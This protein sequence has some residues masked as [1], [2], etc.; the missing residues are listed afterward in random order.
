MKFVLFFLTL[1][2]CTSVF[3]IGQTSR[4]TAFALFAK[5]QSTLF[6]KAYKSKDLE[7][8]EALL[9]EFVSRYNALSK[10]EQKPYASYVNSYYNVSCA[11]SLLGN[12]QMAI[13]NLEKAIKGGYTNYAHIVADNDLDN[14]RN[15]K[16]FIALVE[17]LRSI[18]DYLYILKADNKRFTAKDSVQTLAFTYQSSDNPSLIQLRKQFKL[19]SIAGEGN[20]V[21]KMINVL[22]WVH[23]TIQH[24]GQHESGIKVINGLEIASVTKAKSIGVSC[25]ELATVLNDCYL[26]LGFKSR[27][28]YCMPKDTLNNDYD[29]HVI[30]AVYSAQ[31]KKWLWMDPTNDAYVMNEKGELLGIDE[32]RN[33]LVNDQPLILNP[34]ANWNHRAS[35]TKENYLY[36]YMAKNLYRFSCILENCFD[37]ETPGEGK[38]ITRVNLAP[39]GYARFKD[40]PAKLAYYNKDLKTSTVIY[41][42]HNP[43]LFWQLP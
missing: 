43:A 38:T 21:S 35:T 2:F 19:D 13:A 8:C 16:S 24:D 41:T 6:L 25:G 30:N 18:S 5:T 3:A 10:E 39:V 26:A 37:I 36:N 14:I 32:V 20:E 33:R 31:L 4:D 42:I 15:E 22:H 40:R 1:T 17:P 7:Q 11:Y 23:N 27:K 12:K 28:V 34:D 9:K 29:S